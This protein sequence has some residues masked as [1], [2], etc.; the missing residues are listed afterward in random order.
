MSA[1]SVMGF[2]GF[3]LRKWHSYSSELRTLIDQSQK[4]HVSSQQ[5][6]IA[7]KTEERTKAGKILGV[8]WDEDSDAFTFKNE[9]ELQTKLVC[10]R[11]VLQITASISIP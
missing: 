6:D 7:N 2:G 4:K 10:K 3:N 1:K 9:I 5:Y 11:T 8:L